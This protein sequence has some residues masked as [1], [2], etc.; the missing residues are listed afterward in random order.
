MTNMTTIPPSWAH[1]GRCADATR[2][3]LNLSNP[4]LPIFQCHLLEMQSKTSE[5]DSGRLPSH[6]IPSRQPPA[7]RPS[8]DGP[9]LPLSISKFLSRRPA[10]CFTQAPVRNRPFHRAQFYNRF[11]I[12]HAH[13]TCFERFVPRRNPGDRVGTTASVGVAAETVLRPVFPRGIPGKRT[14][15]D[16]TS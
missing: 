3:R 15:L 8:L 4:R 13:N 16:G 6:Q 9:L 2:A 1:S 14:W 5:D 11:Q 12:S 7:P 10:P